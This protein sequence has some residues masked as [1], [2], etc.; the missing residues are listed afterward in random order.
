MCGAHGAQQVAFKQAAIETA[1]RGYDKFMIVGG[2]AD[3]RVIGHTPVH[4]QSTGYGGAVAYGGAPMISHGQGL[5]VKVFRDGDPVASNAISARQTLG[6][7][8]QEIANKGT[9]TCL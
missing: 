1:R 4:V 8:W 5:V 9:I 2:Q 7:D 6:P 3:A